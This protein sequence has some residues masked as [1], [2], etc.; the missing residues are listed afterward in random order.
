MSSTSWKSYGGIYKTHKINNL[1]VGTI[2][3]DRIIVRKQNL[4]VQIIEDNVVIEGYQDTRGNVLATQNT[5][6]IGSMYAGNSV[7]VDN[8]ILFIN[9]VVDGS[10]DGDGNP[11]FNDSANPISNVV[12][13]YQNT[14]NYI[15]GNSTS[16]GIGTDAPRKFLEIYENDDIVTDQNTETTMLS[17]RSHRNKTNSVLVSNNDTLYS[18]GVK[19]RA[20]GN[21]G[22]LEFHASDLSSNGNSIATLQNVGADFKIHN[23]LSYG[24]IYIDALTIYL[25]SDGTTKMDISNNV[26]ISTQL[27]IFND[28]SNTFLSEYYTDVSSNYQTTDAIVLNG[29]DASSN[30]FQH[31]VNVNNKG[32]SIGGGGF[33]E[34]NTIS[35]GTLG[36]IT[37][38]NSSSDSSFVPTMTI[39]EGTLSKVKNRTTL[40]IN[41]YSP[42]TNDYMLDINGKT[43]ISHGEI[44]VRA[45]PEFVVSSMSFSKDNLDYGMIVGTSLTNSDTSYN[46]FVTEDGGENW[47][48]K[49]I[50]GDGTIN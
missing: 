17:V 49:E 13:K 18:A 48:M 12:S 45:K 38:N 16:I 39:C 7:Y 41:T 33:I 43:R 34:D 35:T 21:Q 22:S 28:V 3:T 32:L 46:A 11:I 9:N 5:V 40:G 30:I 19:A 23:D 6:S 27:T 47:T 8:R 26:Q 24:N 31:F 44:H 15:G 20:S 1:G 36:L 25:Q 37:N 14:Y 42:N 29:N 10:T 50:V 4:T 2:V